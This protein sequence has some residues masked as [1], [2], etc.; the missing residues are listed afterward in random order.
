MEEQSVIVPP[1]SHAFVVRIW[2]E[3]GLTRPNGCPLWRGRVQHVGSGRT[4]VFQSL[5]ELTQFIWEHA[6]GEEKE[7]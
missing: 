5:D 4:M 7:R 1:D 3:A 2:W 6:G